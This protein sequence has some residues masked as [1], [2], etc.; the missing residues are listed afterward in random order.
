[1]SARACALL[2]SV[3][4]F[5]ADPVPVSAQDPTAASRAIEAMVA[6][7]TGPIDI[8]VAQ[9]GSGH[10]RTVQEAV[11]AVPAGTAARPVVVHIK[12][13]TYR[14]LVYVQREKRFFRFVGDDPLTTVI[15]F[16]LHAN[17][18]G[19]DGKP[20]GT[21][22][23]PTTIIDA[24][25]FVA[26]N[27]TFENGAGPKGQALAI[28]VDGDRVVFRNCRFLGWQDTVFLNRGRQY[29]EDCYINGHVD[30]VFGGATAYFER[31]H[32]H[33][34]DSGYITAASTPVDVRYGFVF[35]RGR[36]TG[37]PDAKTY[38]GRPWR[39]HAATTFLETEMSE[40]VR[41]A[42]WHN[43]NRA[44]REKT[45]RYAE[46][47]SRGPGAGVDGRVPWAAVLTR[48]QAAALTARE[49]LRG[50]DGWEPPVTR[51]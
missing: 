3:F 13:G 31:C 40:A 22:R 43:W 8:N 37:E 29:F 28:R 25:D 34:R 39:D 35:A 32:L 46:Y 9:D 45:A 48:D 17:L 44:E 21:W 6:S 26:E 24:D 19:P 1:M 49:V 18:T 33:V 50:L 47:A 5:A 30:F 11:M 42:G 14:E 4:V 2:A 12:P 7:G 38:L 36:I 27:V 16:D 10:F 41:P 23:T 15:T 51:K 20:L